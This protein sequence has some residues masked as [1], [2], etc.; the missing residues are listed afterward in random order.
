MKQIFK[1]LWSQRAQNVWLLAELVLVCFVAWKQLD[2]IA[3]RMYYR[4]LP[5]GIDSERLVVAHTAPLIL[6]GL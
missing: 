1:N 2:P 4:S 5:Q 3:V 6:G